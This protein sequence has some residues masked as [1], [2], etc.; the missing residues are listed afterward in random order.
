MARE[1][2]T[3]SRAREEVKAQE[4]VDSSGKRT[5]PRRRAVLSS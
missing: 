3:R 5:Q 4:G 1:Y 2:S